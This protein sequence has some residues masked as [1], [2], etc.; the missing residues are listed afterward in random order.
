MREINYQVFDEKSGLPIE[1][2][3]DG[4]VREFAMRQD[5]SCSEIFNEMKDAVKKEGIK[6]MIARGSDKIKVVGKN[7]MSACQPTYYDDYDKA[8]E[9]LK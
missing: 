6:Y 5:K 7:S 9:S 3:S 1:S 8:L 2:L 4:S